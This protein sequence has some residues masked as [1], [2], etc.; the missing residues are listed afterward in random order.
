MAVRVTRLP[1][2]VTPDPN[3]VITR[4]FSPGDRLRRQDIIRRVLAYSEPE[5]STLL[6]DVERGF[7]AKHPDLIEVLADHFGEVR[8]DVPA[9]TRSAGSASS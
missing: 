6:A 4:F 1:L 9:R 5:V 2:K 3:R 7:R 8:D